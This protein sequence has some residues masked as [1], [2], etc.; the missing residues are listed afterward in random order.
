M[1]SYDWKDKSGDLGRVSARRGYGVRVM[2][3]DFNG[4]VTIHAVTPAKAREIAAA[5][6]QAAEAAEGLV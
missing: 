6:L 3:W 5:L 2:L 1:I 4:D